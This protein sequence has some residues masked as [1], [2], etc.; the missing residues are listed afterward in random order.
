MNIEQIRILSHSQPFRPFEIHIADGRSV[1]VKHPDFLA[2]GGRSITV[3]EDPEIA[4]T[5]DVRLI[6]SI[7]PSK[8]SSSKRNGH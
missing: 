5:I 7:E 2:F 1:R 6:T 4:E 8:S 3:Y